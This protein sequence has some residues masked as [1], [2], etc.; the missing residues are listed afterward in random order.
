MVILAQLAIII[1][2]SRFYMDRFTYNRQKA[3]RSATNFM[4]LNSP[5][6]NFLL[7]HNL[8]HKSAN[9]YE[10]LLLLKSN[11]KMCLEK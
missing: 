6:R 2:L 4:K 8:V 3:S 5:R 7:I 10:D 9:F 11:A 1:V